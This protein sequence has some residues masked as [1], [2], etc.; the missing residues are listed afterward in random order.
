MNGIDGKVRCGSAKSPHYLF[1]YTSTTVEIALT[2]L[3]MV[4]LVPGYRQNVLGS[5][6]CLP[7]GA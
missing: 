5:E 6:I 3:P 1:Y 2:Y 7:D 4:R